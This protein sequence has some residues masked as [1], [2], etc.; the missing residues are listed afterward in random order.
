[1]REERNCVF[2]L[3]LIELVSGIRRCIWSFS[4]RVSFRFQKSTDLLAQ[5]RYLDL[6]V[7]IVQKG[8]V[9]ATELAQERKNVF[10]LRF[11]E[12]HGHPLFSIMEV[13]AGSIEK[14]SS[15]LFLNMYI[16][17][18]MAAA[19][20]PCALP[21]LNLTREQK[22][23]LH[24]TKSH[25]I[26]PKLRSQIGKDVMKNVVLLDNDGDGYCGYHCLGVIN[27]LVKHSYVEYRDIV[28]RLRDTAE[29]KL[30]A[31]NLR[32]MTGQ[33]GADGDVAVQLE[34]YLKAPAHE[35]ESCEISWY[36]RDYGINVGVIGY[37]TEGA[38]R[39]YQVQ[40]PL[41]HP[42]NAIWIF[43]LNSNR[44]HWE[45]LAKKFKGESKTDTLCLA[46]VVHVPV[47]VV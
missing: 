15:E 14:K 45:L 43:F 34:A 27:Y 23:R 44:V 36:L 38:R 47:E 6:S 11:G 29:E 9:S 8:Q 4:G 33:A 22:I 21:V 41:Y 7:H 18:K 25:P 39:N 42:D 1:M 12:V 28:K 10:G 5:K 24:L 20:S 13:R 40:I 2:G 31:Q 37:S 26:P 16:Q 30:C 35:L 3:H 19:N 17:A 32:L 46:V